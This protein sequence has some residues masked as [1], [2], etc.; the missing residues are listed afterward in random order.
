MGT[1]YQENYRALFDGW[2][3]KIDTALYNPNTVNP[4]A[5]VMNVAVFV[6]DRPFNTSKGIVKAIG[7]GHN[8]NGT[9]QG[10]MMKGTKF[11]ESGASGI[12]FERAGV[13]YARAA[14]VHATA[15]ISGQLSP[16]G[17]VDG[18]VVFE[19]M[20]WKGTNVG[21]VPG[22]THYFTGNYCAGRLLSDFKTASK[23]V[24]RMAP[25]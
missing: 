11:G 9:V 19:I 22:P 20:G 21:F 10:H 23:P 8:R 13:T 17:D 5:Q 12:Q 1:E 14:H 15:F 25:D 24:P 6:P 2:N 18:A 3:C 7:F 16:N 4:L